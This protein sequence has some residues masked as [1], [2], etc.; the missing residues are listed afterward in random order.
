MKKE[1]QQNGMDFATGTVVRIEE[2]LPVIVSATGEPF[3]IK[4]GSVVI[5][6]SYQVMPFID[7]NDNLQEIKILTLFYGQQNGQSPKYKIL[8]HTYFGDVSN[9]KI[10]PLLL[11]PGEALGA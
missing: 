3:I 9:S 10:K 1:T 8:K 7:R 4:K 5:V 6:E 11:K 2:A